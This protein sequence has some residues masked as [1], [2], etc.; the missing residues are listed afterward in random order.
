[1]HGETLQVGAR[2]SASQEVRTDY[3][4]FYLFP[5]SGLL[6]DNAYKTGQPVNKS[7]IDTAAK[8]M[9]EK[10]KN[11]CCHIFHSERYMKSDIHQL[12]NQ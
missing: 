6:W 4:S 12:G 8:Y 2:G 1:M 11:H 9:Q 5:Q 10:K 3:D 7:L